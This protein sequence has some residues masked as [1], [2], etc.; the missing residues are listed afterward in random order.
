MDMSVVRKLGEWIGGSNNRA[1]QRPLRRYL[2]SAS[3]SL[4]RRFLLS[5]QVLSIASRP[6]GNGHSQAAQSTAAIP[7]NSAGQ[8]SGHNLTG[9]VRL[10]S[11]HHVVPT[12]GGTGSSNATI[13]QAF[14]IAVASQ[15]SAATP[16]EDLE[17]AALLQGTD[18][19]TGGSLGGLTGLIDSSYGMSRQA[20]DSAFTSP[21]ASPT[22]SSGS[23][24]LPI[25]DSIDGISG[26]ATG[27]FASG[28]SQ[29][30]IDGISQM[31]SVYPADSSAGFLA[32]GISFE[33]NPDLALTL[34]F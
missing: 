31:Q 20:I 21:F 2:R 28:S 9:A 3:E 10:M 27:S 11:L 26:I 6:Q 5:A 33:A 25:S 22:G 17:L 24:S 15:E 19:A 18:N 14:A 1:R 13:D 30:H 12:I 34:A 32:S 4:E 16:F 29:S 23:L 7:N 8:S